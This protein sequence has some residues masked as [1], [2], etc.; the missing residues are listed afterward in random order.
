M[1]YNLNQ[2]SF[3][4][5]IRL[6]FLRYNHWI[7]NGTDVSSSDDN[8]GE[9]SSSDDDGDNG[10]VVI[11]KGED[12]STLDCG[13][14]EE[15]IGNTEGDTLLGTVG[16]IND[17]LVGTVDAENGSKLDS[18]NEEDS[19]VE[20][21]SSFVNEVI[22]DGSS[23][24][25]DVEEDGS[26]LDTGGE[27]GSKLENVSSVGDVEI[28]SLLIVMSL[29]EGEEEEEAVSFCCGVDVSLFDNPVCVLPSGSKEVD[30]PWLDG[31]NSS[32]AFVSWSLV[33]RLNNLW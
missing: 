31:C 18:D 1:W 22:E 16:V 15:D 12:D 21:T 19:G 3:K 14:T 29:D 2:K 26:T 11:G 32:L 28:S 33:A 30:S 8:D 5:N 27:V 10:L 17:S 4:I 7:S 6:L 24:D 13:L 25:F 23:V 9:D 20:E